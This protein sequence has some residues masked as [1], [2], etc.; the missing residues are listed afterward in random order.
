MCISPLRPTASRT[1]PPTLTPFW[2]TVEIR[3]YLAP[4]TPIIPPGFPKQGM[5]GRHNPDPE[6]REASRAGSL[7]TPISLICPALKILE[8]LNLK[9]IVEALGTRPSQH[10]FKP[11]HSTTSAQ[12]PIF[13]RVVCGFN[14]CKPPSRTIT[15]A[16]DI[17]KAFDTISHCLLIEMIHSSRL[18]LNLVR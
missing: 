18:C 1:T 7:L 3:W 11:R 16:V 9:S 17:S 12:L 6:G 2:R 5:T 13:A 14:H 4:L 15:I 8:R 10:G